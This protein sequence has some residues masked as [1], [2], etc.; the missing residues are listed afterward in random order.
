MGG[1]IM[2]YN[3]LK[4]LNKKDFVNQI[5]SHCSDNGMRCKLS[6]IYDAMRK[7]YDGNIEY[8][9]NDIDE[10]LEELDAM[11]SKEHNLDLWIRSVWIVGSLI[12]FSSND[13]DVWIVGRIDRIS[14]NGMLQIKAIENRQDVELKDF[15]RNDDKTVRPLSKAL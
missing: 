1:N 14:D 7:Y 8:D 13:A 9:D 5:S 11:N 6:S 10:I 15:D 3:V 12:E 2:D 4:A